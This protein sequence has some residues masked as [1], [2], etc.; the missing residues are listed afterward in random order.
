MLIRIYLEKSE[1]FPTSKAGD[2]YVVVTNWTHNLFHESTESVEE[3]VTAPEG[4]EKNHE[5]E[6]SHA[7]GR[8]RR[9]G[10]RR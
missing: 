8:R 6:V 1:T 9:E 10:V 2:T 4:E 7:L 3:S 5:W